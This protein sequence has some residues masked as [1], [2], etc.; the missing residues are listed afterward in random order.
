MRTARIATT[1]IV[2]ICL[3]VLG[4]LPARGDTVILANGDMVSGEIR[5]AELTVMTPEGPVKIGRGNLAA[6]ELQT[7]SG[8]VS[9]L[10]T[11]RTVKGYIDQAAYEV[12]LPSGQTVIIPRSAVAVLRFL[13]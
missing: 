10:R 5:L 13:R 9:S 6:V 11:G 4:A 7:A 1:A 2:T 3:C 12:R 8:D